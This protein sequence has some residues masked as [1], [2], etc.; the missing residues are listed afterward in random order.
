[1]CAGPGYYYRVMFH[2]GL[3]LWVSFFAVTNTISPFITRLDCCVVLLSALSLVAHRPIGFRN[4][5]GQHA[6]RITC[7]ARRL[8]TA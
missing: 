4:R 7:V 8:T 5:I 6:V 2:T 3:G 1:V